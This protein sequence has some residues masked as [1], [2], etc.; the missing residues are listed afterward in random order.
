MTPA[1]TSAST[2]GTKMI[3]RRTPWPRILRLSSS[4]MARPSGSWMTIETTTMIRLCWSASMKT[5]VR[6]HARVVLEA[7][8]VVQRAEPVPAVDREL[9][10]LDDRHQHEDHEQEQRRRHEEERSRGACASRSASRGVRPGPGPPAA[11]SAAGDRGLRGGRAG[12]AVTPTR[13][14]ASSAT[15]V[16]SPRQPPPAWRRR[17]PAGSPCRRTAG[18]SRRSWRRR[19]SAPNAVSR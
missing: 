17:C 10:G 13:A 5:V 14:V 9:D 1:M 12:E 6:Q 15:S 8:E 11:P 7:D 16:T 3:M 4:A 18:R 2:Y 19:R